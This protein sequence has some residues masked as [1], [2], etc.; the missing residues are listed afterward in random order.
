MLLALTCTASALGCTPALSLPSRPAAPP[1]SPLAAA[2]QIELSL[3]DC[4]LK[5]P[6][7]LW[8]KGFSDAVTSSLS[9]DGSLVAVSGVLPRGG[10]RRMEVQVYGRDGVL[11]WSRHL[12]DPGFRS[13]WARFLADGEHLALGAFY[14]NETGVVEV[15]PA[16]G[17]AALWRRRA[18]GPVLVTS[19]EQG[20]RLAV[21]DHLEG[22]LHLL[23]AGTGTE[24]ARVRV[25]PAATCQFVASGEYLLV[26][27]GDRLFLLDGAGRHAW[28]HRLDGSMLREVGI[29]RDAS[30]L[31][32]TTGEA[33]SSVYLFDRDGRLRWK[34]LLFPGGTNLVRFSPDSRLLAV[35]NVGRRAGIYLFRTG[36]GELLWRLFFADGAAHGDISLRRLE[37]AP[38]CGF[39][40]VEAVVGTATGP[41]LQE[42]HQVI[43]L[44]PS[45]SALWRLPLGYDLDLA[46]DT[47][48]G[49]VVATGRPQVDASGQAF[50]SVRCYDLTP[51]LPPAASGAASD[52]G[53]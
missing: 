41:T 5:S 43:L 50:T 29:S 17:G 12:Q 53:R 2:P 26:E 1:P 38:D 6:A 14:Y 28:E 32:V 20:D 46:L 10:L 36:T 8:E 24:L 15:Y 4:P 13:G 42:E 51:L 48:C 7:P 19:S 40:M 21:I 31:A 45:G 35:Y 30:W 3:S 49:T 34:Y 23:S 16:G 9:P 33:D 39:L 44:D 11:Q 25:G 27:D 22:Y 52:R 47:G 18:S 37:F